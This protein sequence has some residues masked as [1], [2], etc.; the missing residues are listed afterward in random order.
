MGVRPLTPADPVRVGP[1]LL[2]GRLGEGGMGT[3][4]L[5]RSAGGRTVAVKVIRTDLAGDPAFRDRFRAEVAAARAAS[6]AFTAPVVDADTGAEAPWLA[7]AFVP[8]IPLH[9]AVALGG[10]LE[11]PAL[12]AVAAGVAEALVNIHAAGLI[13]RDLKPSNVLLA[14][15]GP[16]V[17]DFGI[18]RAAAGP[19]LTATGL[20]LGTPAYM[21]PEQSLGDPLTPASDVFSLG[22][23]L[24]FAARG[25]APFAG[26]VSALELQRRIVQD[27]PDLSGVPDGIR[28]LIAACMAKNPLDRPE[29]RQVVEVV[30]RM[31]GVP[32]RAGAWLPPLLVEAVEAVAAVLA[33][34]LPHRPGGPAADGDDPG[35]G[36]ASGADSGGDAQS[37]GPDIQPP[38]V[39][40]P[41][42]PGRR[43]VLLGLAGGGLALAAGGAVAARALRGAG[44][45]RGAGGTSAAALTDPA[46]SLATD[47]VAKPLWTAETGGPVTQVTGDANTVVAVTGTQ[48]RAFDLAGKPRW[49]P[50]PNVSDPSGAYLAGDPAAV[51]DGLLFVMSR[52]G[53]AHQGRVLH[54]LDLA[55]GKEAWRIAARQDLWIRWAWIPGILDGVVYVSGSTMPYGDLDAALKGGSAG[56]PGSKAFVWAVDPAARAIRWQVEVDDRSAGQ[57]RLKVP[58]S[59]NRL[60]WVTANA[61]GSAPR[62]TALATAEGGKTL[63]EQPTPGGTGNS[64]STYFAGLVP[65][66]NDG[67]HS[68]AGDRFLLLS[69]H[70]YAVDAANGQVAWASQ[71][72]TLFYTAAA[73]PDGRTVYGVAAGG[74]GTSVVH[75]FGAR[76]GTVRWAGTLPMASVGPVAV[77]ATSDTVY[78]WLRG[79]LWALA[80]DTGLAR[81]SHELGGAGTT[82]GA[83]QI[84]LWAHGDRVYGAGHQGVTALSTAGR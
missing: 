37:S 42:R 16:F 2:L 3:V 17:I 5:G 25:T 30:E 44:G 26:P 61:D 77:Q 68:S 27:E 10:P 6:G 79:R 41:A 47:T 56:A 63:W 67:P 84:A 48:V 34:T 57:S 65:S 23:T 69:D 43:K 52:A 20:V 62:M 80:A 78:V 60:L 72:K 18:A 46:R 81:W 54:A 75:A 31:A 70:L 28:L 53:A 15:D 40:V 71:G 66:W 83:A 64:L 12:W 7:T 39:P 76:D 33:P 49:E 36:P 82:P 22:S 32:R 45:G 74:V 73:S 24:A 51:A 19:A 58:S 8:G 1:Y 29:P 11:E 35:Q 50:V 14:L 55:T 59:G 4:F 38:P 9:E 21:S 13:H